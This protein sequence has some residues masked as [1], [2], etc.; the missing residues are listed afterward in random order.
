M[1]R[2]SPP[3]LSA[4]ARR[5]AAARE[6]LALCARAD[7]LA[8]EAEA[9]VSTDDHRLL[10]MLEQRDALLQD[11]A[12][13]LVVLRLERPAADSP[14]YAATERMMDDA[15]MLVD[16]L[17]AALQASQRVTLDL[18][19]RVARRSEELRAELDAMQR[20]SVAGQAY[21]IP[22]GGQLVDRRR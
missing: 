9:A 20:A 1:L 8:R 6:A 5:A 16:E 12:E 15:D 22:A 11:L 13:Q 2:S 19:A 18:A 3:S 10:A 21:G 4:P 7:V 17:T 14:L